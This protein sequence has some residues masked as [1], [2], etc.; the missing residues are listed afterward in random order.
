MCHH[1]VKEINANKTRRGTD[2]YLGSTAIRDYGGIRCFE[3]IS[4]HEK[5]QQQYRR[6]VKEML[7][8]KL[9]L[10][11]EMDRRLVYGNPDFSRKLS[12]NFKV[13]AKIREVGRPFK[14]VESARKENK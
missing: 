13:G 2:I 3:D 5:V 11:G 4:K 12:K 7:E 8:K 1:V 14:K 9:A 10:K 6:F